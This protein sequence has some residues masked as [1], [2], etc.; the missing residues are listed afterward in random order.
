METE[1]CAFDSNSRDFGVVY[2]EQQPYR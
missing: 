2:V 1:I